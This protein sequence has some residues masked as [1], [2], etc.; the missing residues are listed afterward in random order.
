MKKAAAIRRQRRNY[1]KH[2]L[3]QL[4]IF[5]YQPISRSQDYQGHNRLEPENRQRECGRTDHL[6]PPGLLQ[7][8]YTRLIISAHFSI[9]NICPLASLHLGL[10]KVSHFTADPVHIREI[11]IFP[12]GR[13]SFL[14]FVPSRYRLIPSLTYAADC[15]IE[16]L[17]WIV[18]VHGTTEEE[19]A[20]QLRYVKALKCLQ[21]ALDDAEECL[22]PETLCAAELL[23]ILEVSC[24]LRLNIEPWLTHLQA[25][26]YQ[27]RAFVDTPCW[28]RSPI[29]RTSGSR[30]G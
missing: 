19:C 3:R 27:E 2:N 21:A 7:G 9:L 20:V 24:A 23:G 16:R 28:R 15:L 22:T 6:D 8:N 10:A 12:F 14:S 25:P 30:S 4:P 5:L 11:F 18:N 29:D 13:T 17:R 26:G 1:G